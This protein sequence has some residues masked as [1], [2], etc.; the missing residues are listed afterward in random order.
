MNSSNQPPTAQ[1]IKEAALMMFTESGYE[2]TSMSEIAKVVGIKTPSIYSHYKSKEQLF[3]QLCEQGAAEELAQFYKLMEATKQES[4]LE[5]IYEVFDFFTDFNHL[6]AGQS[7]FKRTMLVPPR[8]LRDHLRQAVMKLE[9]AINV[10]LNELFVQGRR[11]GVLNEQNGERML[12]VFYNCIDGLLVEF[13]IY[14]DVLFLERKQ[15]IWESLIR[16]WTMG[17]SD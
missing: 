5:R 6:T 11:E 10:H 7:F 8:H 13:Q 3:L 2:G 16:L 14:E 9:D 15:M 12:A 1:R 4:I 17:G